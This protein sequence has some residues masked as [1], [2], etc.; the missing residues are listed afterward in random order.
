M[1]KTIHI[2]YMIEDT[3]IRIL[4]I[5]NSIGERNSIRKRLLKNKVVTNRDYDLGRVRRKTIVPNV[6]YPF[7][8][9]P[10]QKVN[11]EILI[12][13]TESSLVNHLG[14]GEKTE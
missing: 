6:I 13:G 3:G 1:S 11:D 9:N 4:A 5:C 14:K 10:S 8:I 7:G 2:V 12:E